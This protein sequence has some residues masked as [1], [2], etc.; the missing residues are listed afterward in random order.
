MN[1]AF[2][3]VNLRHPLM[4]PAP[5]QHSEYDYAPPAPPPSYTLYWVGISLLTVAF[6]LALLIWPPYFSGAG[7]TGEPASWVVFFGRFHPIVLHLP[8]GVLAISLLI[9]VGSFRSIFEEKWRDQALF[10]AFVGAVG[11]VVAVMFGIFLSREGDFAGK[12]N[13]RAHQLLCLVSAFT[14]IAG[15]FARLIYLTSMRKS[16]LDATR[17]I[18]FGTAAV[19]GIGAHFGGNM[20]HGDKYLTEFAP[21]A[22]AGPMSAMDNWVR[23]FFEKKK[24]PAKDEPKAAPVPATPAK[25]EPAKQTEPAKVEPAKT[26]PPTPTPAPAAGGNEKLVF[27]HIILPILEAKCN[28]C[29]NEAKSKGDLRMDTYELAM[30]GGENGDNIVAGDPDKSLTVQRMVLPLDDDEHMPP[31]GKDQP[32][33]EEME[34]IKWWIKEGASNTLTVSAAKIPDA[35]KATADEQLKK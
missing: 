9:E 31:E 17:F 20:S 35:L 16:L 25:A 34:L 10:V 1:G 21:P 26:A 2:L 22:V 15:V 27:Q 33:K 3:S 18:L 6:F 5:S 23:S 24:E 28:K 4:T 12:A 8:V 32:T 13:L 30:K 11:A 7:A 14:S 19:M 29:H